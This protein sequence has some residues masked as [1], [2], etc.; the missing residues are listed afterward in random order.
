[1]SESVEEED[2]EEGRGRV[3]RGDEAKRGGRAKRETKGV[4]GGEDIVGVGG[5]GE[6]SSKQGCCSREDVVCLA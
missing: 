2:E 3:E 4:L 6:M 1:M 5:K